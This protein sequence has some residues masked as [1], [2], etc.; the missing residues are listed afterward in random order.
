MERKTLYIPINIKTRQE[1]FEGYGQ[2]E[3]YKTIAAA[4]ICGIFCAVLYSLTRSMAMCIVIFL[5]TVA[6]SVMFLTKDR[7]NLSVLDQIIHMVRFS[8]SQKTY[9]Y[10]YIDEWRKEHA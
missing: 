7:N 9:K 2:S 6:A 8:K 1:Y 10:T 4:A 5:S 3:L